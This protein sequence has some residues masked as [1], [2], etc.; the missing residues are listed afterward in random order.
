MPRRK[1]EPGKGG[2]W[3]INPEY[4]NL[5]VNGVYKSK[6]RTAPITTS[7][8]YHYGNG[9]RREISRET[10]VEEDSDSSSSSSSNHTGDNSPMLTSASCLRSSLE[11]KADADSKVNAPIDGTEH[12]LSSVRI[13]SEPVDDHAYH[14]EKP[15]AGL[16]DSGEWNTLLSQDIMVGGVS[17]K[18]EDIIDSQADQP[19]SPAPTLSPP[20]SDT[21]SDDIDDIFQMI[22]LDKLEWE[23]FP[24]DYESGTPLDLTIVGTSINRPNNWSE[25]CQEPHA[26]DQSNSH[27]STPV[28]D[29]GDLENFDPLSATQAAELNEALA[30]LNEETDMDDF[31]WGLQSPS[32]K[33]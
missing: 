29:M 11:L 20:I 28:H 24:T 8:P 13:K 21:N 23:G 6:R 22:D 9:Y 17:V 3:R 19:A 7:A 33:I 14:L 31:L 27:M 12:F 32:D 18:A 5:F 10:S 1:D 4:E 26:G 25:M 16:Y 15:S 30:A 2:F